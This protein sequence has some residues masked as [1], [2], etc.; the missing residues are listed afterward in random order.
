M[1]TETNIYDI[2]GEIIRKVGDNHEFTLPEAQEKLKYYKEKLEE[3]Q[4]AEN[5][6]K[7]KIAAYNTYITNLANYVAFQASKLTSDELLDMIGV[8]NLKKTD[9]EDIN[10]ALNDTETTADTANEIQESTPTGGESNTD[11]ESGDAEIVGRELSDIHEERPV[12]QSDLL[13]ERDNVETV[14]DE[15]VTPVE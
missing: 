5:P 1:K 3:A 13:V 10:N 12:S 2:D 11:E 6:D 8:N 9:A 4:K 7:T 14:M 15:V